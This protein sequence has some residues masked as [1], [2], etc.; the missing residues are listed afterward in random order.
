MGLGVLA[1]Y[2]GGAGGVGRRGTKNTKTL[3]TDLIYSLLIKYYS[4][5]TYR[6]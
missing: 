4:L 3:K 1:L 6:H 5:L 2:R